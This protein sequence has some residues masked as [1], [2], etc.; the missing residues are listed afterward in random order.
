MHKVWGFLEERTVLTLTIA[1]LLNL[2]ESF[3]N[4]LYLYKT[5]LAPSPM[6]PL[7]GLVSATMTL[8]K[9]ILYWAQ[10]YFCNYCA[11]GHNT[12]SDLIVLWIIPNGYYN[13]FA[14]MSLTFTNEYFPR[15]WL[16]FPSFI[17]YALWHDVA[18]ALYVAKKG[19]K[20]DGKVKAH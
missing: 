1:A 10:E 18:G 9:T 7:I 11:V 6:A 14:M 12:L 16:V 17:I 20:H 5:H 8:S 15:L 4:F 19:S 2:V 3:L 13:F